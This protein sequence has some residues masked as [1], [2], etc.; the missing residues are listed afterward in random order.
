MQLLRGSLGTSRAFFVRLCLSASV[1]RSPDML[2]FLEGRM[3]M[4]MCLCVRLPVT[5]SMMRDCYRLLDFVMLENDVSVSWIALHS[6]KYFKL[7]KMKN[8]QVTEVGR[9]T[10]VD[11]QRECRTFVWWWWWWRRF[12]RWRGFLENVRPF[13]PRLCCF[14]L[15]LCGD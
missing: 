1:Y 15:C 11:K 12:P 3:Q 2:N 9:G 5:V 7:V 6:T 8:C 14:L 13:I 4:P 10:T